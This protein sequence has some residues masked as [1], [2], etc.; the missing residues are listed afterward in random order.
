MPKQKHYR[1]LFI[2]LVL[3]ALAAASIWYLTRPKPVEVLVTGVKS[4]SIES[5]VS[6]TRAGTIEACRRARLSPSIG[7]Q[8]TRL[9]VAKG[10]R[11]K[12]RDLLLELWN[13]DARAELEHAHSSVEASRS[14]TRAA[15]LRAEEAQRKSKRLNQLQERG[16]VAEDLADEA[17]TS[18]SSQKAECEASRANL[19]VSESRVA[20]AA[21]SLERTRLYAP[22]DGI[23]AEINAELYE[24]V[25]PS[26]VGIATPPAIDLID[27]SCFYVT[28]PIDE[29][30]A[31]N[32]QLDMPARITL[33]AFAGRVFK[34]RV[35]RIADYV[36]DIEKQARTVDVEVEFIAAEDLK[37]L[38]A[39]Y[40]A[41]VDIILQTTDNVL[42]I[43]TEALL[44][45]DF[46]YVFQAATATLEKRQIK[47]GLSNWNFTQVL[48]GLSAGEQIVTSVDREGI[49]DA[50]SAVI[51][52]P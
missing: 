44:E 17:R 50:A 6:N 45:G 30:D 46:V 9:L 52:K 8:I 42:K 23:V 51:E 27:E 29:V 4:G 22:F 28:A 18:A 35:K 5:T 3:V 15:C 26:P 21:A 36:L 47:S 11:A 39:G 16:V 32:I 1:V 40:S 25:T 37:L 41:D 10:D 2:T 38:L 13:D 7:G 34:G 20:I 33:D 24:Y 12:S 49:A 14:H 19:R 48:E 43:P 31:A